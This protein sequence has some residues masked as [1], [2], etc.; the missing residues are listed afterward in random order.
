MNGSLLAATLATR[1]FR[2][3]LKSFLA[4]SGVIVGVFLLTTVLTL[5]SS[6]RSTVLE[7]FN[8]SF[9][10]NSISVVSRA[11]APGARP[12]T[13]A[14]LREVLAEVPEILY[15]TPLVQGGGRNFSAGGRERYARLTGVGR[16]AQAVMGQPAVEG[17]Y[18]SAEDESARARV[19]LIGG[20]VRESLFPGQPPL[21][22]ALVIDNLVFRVKGV[23]E[24]LGSDPHAGDLD[25]VVLIPYTTLLQ[26]NKAQSLG[27]LRFQAASGAEVEAAA[28]RIRELMRRRHAVVP[29][30]EEDFAVSTSPQGMQDFRRMESLFKKLLPVIGAV[31][32][33]VAGIVIAAIFLAGVKERAA[34]IGLRKAVGARKRDLA[35]QFVAEAAVLSLLGALAGLLLAVPALLYLEALYRRMG[36]ELSLVPGPG[37]AALALLC[38]LATGLLAAWLP[39]RKAA[40][41]NPVEVLR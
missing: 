10:P 36:G 21:G 8:K 9:L 18:I 22:A 39:A 17:E 6:L 14:D 38:A 1:F 26:M 27:A 11:N 2:Y 25:N 28:E 23:L 19:A 3:K 24:P 20:S 40:G 41:L 12:L 34:E 33:L 16:L 32:F 29:G 37:I 31:V 15:W 35:R 30:E 4:M 7:F 5:A 13:E